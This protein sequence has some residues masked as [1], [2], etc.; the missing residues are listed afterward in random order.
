VSRI[1]LCCLVLLLALV[2]P[3]CRRNGPKLAPVSGKVTYRDRGVSRATVQLLPDPGQADRVPTATGQTAED[4]SFT[5]QTPPYGP[6]VVPGHF[7]VTVQHYGSA[8]PP[9]YA[10]PAR[11]SLEVTVPEEGVQDW[12]IKL[13][14]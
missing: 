14:D 1:K 9:K 13:R 3:G 8:V 2:L 12:E 5:L 10:N 7:R 6:G 11:S 4:G